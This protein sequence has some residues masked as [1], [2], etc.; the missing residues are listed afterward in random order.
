MIVTLCKSSWDFERESECDN[1][2]QNWKMIFQVSEAREK[3][4]LD[5]LNNDLHS[6]EPLYSKRGPWLKYF[7]HSNLLCARAIVNHAPIKEYHLCFFPKE[8]FSCLCSNY[9]IET[10]HHILHKCRRFNNYWNL[11]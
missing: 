1:I 2:L 9:P 5:L 6:L 3:H 4:F 10:K 8:N 7:D 11:R